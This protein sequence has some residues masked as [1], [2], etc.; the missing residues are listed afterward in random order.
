[1]SQPQRE[2][3]EKLYP[4]SL[5]VS[6]AS[7][8]GIL[9]LRQR[10]EWLLPSPRVKVD[11]VLPYSAG[12]LLSQVRENGVVEKVDYEDRGV[13]L[14]AYVNDSLASKLMSVAL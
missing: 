8:D 13:A 3:L 2:R 12:S 4:D 1:M 7:G 10:I 5:I 14:I 9:R 11:V 6:A